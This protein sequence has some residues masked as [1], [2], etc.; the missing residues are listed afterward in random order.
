MSCGLA[1]SSHDHMPTSTLTQRHFLCQPQVES[2]AFDHRAKKLAA[3]LL[4]AGADPNARNKS[5]ESA[6]RW[7]QKSA[8]ADTRAVLLEAGAVE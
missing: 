1:C 3:V 2:W 5:G 4:N 8:L 6:L 7:A